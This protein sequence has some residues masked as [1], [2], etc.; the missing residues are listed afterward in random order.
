MLA[1]LLSFITFLLSYIPFVRLLSE[2]FSVEARKTFCAIVLA[3]FIDYSFT[4]LGGRHISLTTITR[5]ARSH[6]LSY[7]LCCIIR[8]VTMF[9]SSSAD[10]AAAAELIK[11][12]NNV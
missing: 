7:T 4:F 6:L 3:Y 11:V 5:E 2:V 8:L 12:T 10:T 1:F 9:T